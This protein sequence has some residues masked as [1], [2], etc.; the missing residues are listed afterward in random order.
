[1]F[2]TYL[3]MVTQ[4]PNYLS[5]AKTYIGRFITDDPESEYNISLKNQL[6]KRLQN[7]PDNTWNHLLSWLFLQQ[8]DYF[9]ALIQEKALHK[10]NLSGLQGIIE[11]GKI[12]FNNSDYNSAKKSFNY[13]L[14]NN[15]LLENE[16]LSKLYLLEID[17]ETNV[18][19]ELIAV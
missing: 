12:A 18:E 13:V 3:N 19:F 2:D 8:K 6:L 14:E 17:L 4:N 7:N 1:M 9:K 16:L 11:I 10:R 5:S 15:P